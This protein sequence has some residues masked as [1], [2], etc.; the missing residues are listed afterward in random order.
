MSEQPQD[1][2]ASELLSELKAENTRKDLL[3][4][5]LC[6]VVALIISISLVAVSGIV[7]GFLWYLNQ[8]DFTSE[9][10]V[11]GVYALVDSEGNVVA[12]DFSTEE[13]QEIQMRARGFSV[14]KISF[15][16]EKIH[17]KEIPGGQYSIS[18]VERRIRS[19]KDKILKVL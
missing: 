5:R 9:Q 4:R 13:I 3:V 10:T 7:A 15:E 17:G 18:K 6:K 19:I 8:Y 2:L 11:S 16:M 14:L 1:F 12:S